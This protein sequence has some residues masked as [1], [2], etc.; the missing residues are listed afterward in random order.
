[1]DCDLAADI[2]NMELKRAAIV[3]AHKGTVAAANEP[4]HAAYFTVTLQGSI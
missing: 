1:M 4:E 3:G 2:L